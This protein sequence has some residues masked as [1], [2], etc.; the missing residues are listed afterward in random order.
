[1]FAAAA[2]VVAGIVFVFLLYALGLTPAEVTQ[3]DYIEYWAAGQQLIHH[4][5]P[6]DF[7]TIFRMER[8]NGME[9]NDP[10]ISFSPPVALE[11]DLPLGWVSAK[12]GLIA[13]LMA[14][15]ASLLAA[16]WLI[17]RLHGKPDSRV[18]LLGIAFAPVIASQMAGQLGTFFLICLVLFL[19]FHRTRPFLA[20]VLLMPFALKP[21]LIVPFA[22]V[23]VLWCFIHKKKS[24][25]LGGLCAVAVSCALSLAIDPHAWK[26]YSR[27]T[28]S[29]PI[30]DW[31]VPTVGMALRKWI[32]PSA[33]WLGY[34]PVALA[35]AWAAWYG[36]KR[37]R[38]WDWLRDGQLLIVVSVVAAPYSWVSD[39]SL[40]LPAILSAL[41]LSTKVDRPLVLFLLIDAILLVEIFVQPLMT[42]FWYLWA[43]PAWLAWYL[44]ATWGARLTP[45]HALDSR[46]VV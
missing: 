36:W 26:Q 35:S 28:A 41:Y 13:W 37:R 38:S 18:H 29:I 7:R 43:A 1:M 39:Q 19:Q 21:H 6:Y 15:L 23:L 14:E 30:A 4:A 12:T 17:W 11:F 44:Y 9:T 32:D 24:L 34:L 25:L 31:F 45:A 27:M 42:S 8:Q 33:R 2:I 40:M 46:A 3:R 10:R 16:I 22:I 20:G 5:D